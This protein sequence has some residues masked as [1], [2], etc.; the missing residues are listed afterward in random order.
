MMATVLLFAV[1]PVFV[2]W[3]LLRLVRS[4]PREDIG[5]PCRK[6]QP[7]GCPDCGRGANN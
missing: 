4:C 2:A 6:W 5:Y 1:V 3:L 7:G